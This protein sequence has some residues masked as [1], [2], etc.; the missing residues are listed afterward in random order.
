ETGGSPDPDYVFDCARYIRFGVACRV[1][2][3]TA[4]RNRLMHRAPILLVVLLSACAVTPPPGPSVTA[5][6][7]QGKDFAAFQQDDLFCR[8]FAAQTGGL[9]PGMAA[10][11]SAVGSAVV[12]TALGAAAGA[13]LGAAAGAAGIGAAAGAGAGL[14]A[15]SAI[16]ANNAAA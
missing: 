11:Q 5:T 8:Q 3:K 16:G 14:L 15:G 6:P 10:S 12:G 2:S 7:G 1:A 9:T 13:A 4:P